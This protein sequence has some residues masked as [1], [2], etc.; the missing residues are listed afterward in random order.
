VTVTAPPR[1]PR[2]SDPVEREDLEALIEALIEEARQRA[3]RRRRIYWAVAALVALV[4]VAVFRVFE[5]SAQSQTAS[6]ALT[7]RSSL[8]TGTGSSKIAFTSAPR[9]G[10]G[11]RSSGLYVVNADASGKRRLTATAWIATPSWSPDGRKL[12]FEGGGMGN[13]YV[14]NADG[15]GQRRLMRNAAAPSWSPDGRRI[16]LLRSGGLYSG[17]G[18]RFWEV[19]VMDADGSGQRR[20]THIAALEGGLAWSPDG[21]KI[22]FVSQRDGNVNHEIYVMN[23]DGSEQRNLTRT[24]GRQED[25]FPWSLR[26]KR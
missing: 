9:F 21:E 3:R 8:P 12:A 4:G 5:R 16:A 14:I 18:G 24:P 10:P 26:Q 1:P 15:S 17:G 6:P 23:A 19:Y 20:L 22:A 25:L 13:V 2:P 11:A 7:A